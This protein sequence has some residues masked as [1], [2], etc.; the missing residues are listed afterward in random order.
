MGIDDSLVDR[1][2]RGV[3]DQLGSTAGSHHAARLRFNEGD[4]RN[5][6]P[7]TG[8]ATVLAES[9]ITEQLLRD[10]LDGERQIRIGEKSILTPSARDFLRA[11]EICWSRQ[12]P[13]AT[14]TSS[15]NTRWCAVV[16][17]SNPTTGLVLDDVERTTD[18]RWKRESARSPQEAAEKAVGALCRDED[19]GVA[20]LTAEAATV[21]CLANRHRRVRAAAV[22]DVADIQA[23]REQMGANLFAINPGEHS[24]Y[25]LKHLL[26]QI[27]AGEAPRVPAGWKE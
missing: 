23:V 15:A 21:A 19:A 7:S 10:Q 25:A 13:A 1:I 27:T 11:R 5:P 22:A 20:V 12:S 24:L 8:Q 9:I 2:V 18:V 4:P 16:A 17:S 26:Q 6:Q 14:A 3:L